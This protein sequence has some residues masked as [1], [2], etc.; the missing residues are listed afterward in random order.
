[1]EKDK[2]GKWCKEEMESILNI[3]STKNKKE[4]KSTNVFSPE[5]G[6]D[7]IIRHNSEL[8][9]GKTLRNLNK[10]NRDIE[11]KGQKIKCKQIIMKKEYS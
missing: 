7:E 5:N 9:E 2:R 4:S 6:N 1:M 10:L 3:K 11:K 8:E